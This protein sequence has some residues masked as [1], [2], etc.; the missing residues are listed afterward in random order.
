M[1]TKTAPPPRPGVVPVILQNKHGG[2]D[3]GDERTASAEA[4]ER[5][6]TAVRSTAS[7]GSSGNGL[8]TESCAGDDFNG[9][10]RRDGGGDGGGRWRS[11]GGAAARPGAGPGGERTP[12]GSPGSPRVAVDTA[13]LCSPRATKSTRSTMSTGAPPHSW[14]SPTAAATPAARSGGQTSRASGDPAG[15]LAGVPAA[16]RAEAGGSG[17]LRGPGGT[18]RCSAEGRFRGGGDAH[19]SIGAELCKG[20]VDGFLVR[21]VGAGGSNAGVQ[22]GDG[23]LVT[24]Q[25]VPAVARTARRAIPASHTIRPSAGRQPCESRRSED[26]RRQ[27]KGLHR[28]NICRMRYDGMNILGTVCLFARWV[29]I[30]D[31][32]SAVEWRKDADVRV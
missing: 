22:L 27:Y 28:G 3:G 25:T 13:G 12:T 26:G 16:T 15:P 32:C 19:T 4:A 11:G 6:S 23:G 30:S 14:A 18:T 17:D 24:A 1:C 9:A 29:W 5:G 7:R 10:S 2:E 20:T 8:N 21:G 31:S